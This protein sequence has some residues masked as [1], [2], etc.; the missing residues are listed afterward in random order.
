MMLILKGTIFFIISLAINFLLLSLFC[1][2]H[3]VIYILTLFTALYIL[4]RYYHYYISPIFYPLLVFTFIVIN[5]EIYDEYCFEF[6]LYFDYVGRV[7]YI[8]SEIMYGLMILHLI[9]L[10]NLKKFEN[11]WDI[12]DKKIF[13]I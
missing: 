6:F 9:L 1:T 11:I 3:F 5:L 2:N 8:N 10:V 12:I 4:N 13:R 7:I